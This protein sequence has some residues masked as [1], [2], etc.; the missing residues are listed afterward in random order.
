MGEFPGD[1]RRS[2]NVLLP[3]NYS[4]ILLKHVETLK[5][6]G[7]K[8]SINWC[9]ISCIHSML[10][11]NAIDLHW[12]PGKIDENWPLKQEVGPPEPLKN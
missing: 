5:I 10:A 7:Y 8:T 1:R 12:D 4:N 6:M 9:R 3:I 2:S 11:I